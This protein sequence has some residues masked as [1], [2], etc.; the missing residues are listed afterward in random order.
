MPVLWADFFSTTD[1]LS[2]DEQWAYAKLLAK[3]WLRNCRPF[4]DEPRDLARLLN[5]TVKRWLKIRPR[6]V[7]FFDLSEGTWRQENLEKQF[8]F[9]SQ[10][11]A[12]SRSN[13]SRGGRPQSNKINEVENP[14]G[15]IQVTQNEP[16]A[17][18]TKP[19]P[20]KEE[21]S[22][23]LIEAEFADLWQLYPRHIGKAAALAK[24]RIARRVVDAETIRVGVT[25]YAAER[26][27][28]DH[29]Y[30]LH[31]ATWLHQGR[32]TDEAAPKANGNGH[33]TGDEERDQ[34]RGRVG[35]WQAKHLWA[36][37]L[38]GPAPGEPRCGVPAEI[39]REFGYV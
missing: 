32:W 36:A 37:D 39:L 14:A 33:A 35:V 29:K 38:W 18:L 22:E 11:A 9:V 1:H 5:L 26:E 23:S 6:I 25:A 8:A 17:N 7:G 15:S 20:K 30:T 2:N 10:R 3:T 24:Y 12:I 27:G 4:P 31:L 21:E 16:R 13:G 34:W 19:K 28:E